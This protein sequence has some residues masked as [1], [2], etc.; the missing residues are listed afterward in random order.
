LLFFR[1]LSFAYKPDCPE[2]NPAKDKKAKARERIAVIVV[3]NPDFPN[4]LM[5]RISHF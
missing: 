1:A 2:L 5:L 4:N 3:G